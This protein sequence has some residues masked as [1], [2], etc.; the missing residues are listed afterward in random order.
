[1]C[2]EFFVAVDCEV[3][4][5]GEYSECS[6]PCGLGTTTRRR[7]V[8]QEP[9]NGGLKC[10]TLKESRVCVGKKCKTQRHLGSRGRADL[11]ML[12]NLFLRSIRLSI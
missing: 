9:R 2:A 7:E 8:T 1:M 6:K 4:E 10:P 5:W 3:S 12:N 11:G